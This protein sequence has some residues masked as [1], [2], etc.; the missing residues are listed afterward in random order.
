VNFPPAELQK[1]SYRPGGQSARSSLARTSLTDMASHMALGR[2]SRP[3]GDGTLEL[4]P[5]SAAA[6]M[7]TLKEGSVVERP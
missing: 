1:T 2:V 4:V 3:R 6:P 5:A 7:E